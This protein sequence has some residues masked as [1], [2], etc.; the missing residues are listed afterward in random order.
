MAIR[1]AKFLGTTEEFWVNLQSSYELAV[2]RRTN[3]R[4]VA[5]IKRHTSTAA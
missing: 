4:A 1:P 3:K 5:R 2:A